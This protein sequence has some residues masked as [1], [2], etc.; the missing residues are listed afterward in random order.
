MHPGAQGPGL[1]AAVNKAIR[2]AAGR[3]GGK[4]R[5]VLKVAVGNGGAGRGDLRGYGGGFEARV[6][7]HDAALRRDRRV[8][9]CGSLRDGGVRGFEVQPSRA[10]VVVGVVGHAVEVE[11]AADDCGG[12]RGE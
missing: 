12:R 2:A 7:E 10:D 11:D 4:G 3:D 8:G 1:Q 5:G 6:R 9:V